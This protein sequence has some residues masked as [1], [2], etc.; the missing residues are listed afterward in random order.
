MKAAS[1]LSS[2]VYTGLVVT[3]GLNGLRAAQEKK[4][5]Q[6]GTVVTVGNL[7]SKAPGAWVEEKATTSTRVKQFR[8]P[9]IGDDKDNAEVVIFYF[10]SRGAGTENANV[11]RWQGQFVPPEGKTIDQ[12]TK[13]E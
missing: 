2:A 7:Q 13:T 5:P 1:C 9:A 10:G 3:L 12:A 6:K 11:K 8:L 4:E